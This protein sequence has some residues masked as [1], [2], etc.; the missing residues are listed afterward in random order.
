MNDIKKAEYYHTVYKNLSDS[1]AAFQMNDFFENS[2][3]RIE[4]ETELN[5]IEAHR[6]RIRLENAAF[7]KQL[8]IIFL[9]LGVVIIAIFIIYIL[10]LKFKMSSVKAIKELDLRMNLQGASYRND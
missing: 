7:R 4:V 10:F 6:E 8:T 1:V 5:S 2:M 9:V 3:A